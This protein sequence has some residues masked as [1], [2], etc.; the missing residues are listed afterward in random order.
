MSAAGPRGT[1]ALPSPW[2]S[3]PTT[4]AAHHRHGSVPRR[5]DGLVFTG[6][7]GEDQPEVREEVRARL[8]ALG[9]SGLRTPGAG[10]PEIVSASGAAL[11]VVVPTGEIRQ[12][13][14]ET[15]ALLRGH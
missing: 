7:I 1:S 9:L 14:R 4:A 2:T 8:T 5:L 10:R 15:G 3:S 13:D 12:V 11:S 6:E